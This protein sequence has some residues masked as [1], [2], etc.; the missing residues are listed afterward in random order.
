MEKYNFAIQ[1]S[2]NVTDVMDL[3]CVMRCDKLVIGGRWNDAVQYRY[4]L[5]DGQEAVTYDWIVQLADGKWHVYSGAE[6]NE[7]NKS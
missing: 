2:D 3:P 1:V 7:L 4:M 5:A 6:W